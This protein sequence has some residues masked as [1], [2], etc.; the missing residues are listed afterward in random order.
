MRQ[1]ACRATKLKAVT[2][3]VEASPG[4][5][6]PGM[7]LLFVSTPYGGLCKTKSP[8]APPMRPLEQKRIM[9]SNWWEGSGVSDGR[10]TGIVWRYLRWTRWA[11]LALCPA[12]VVY[13][14]TLLGRKSLALQIGLQARLLP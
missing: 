8:T 12:G 9:V 14:K 5:G 2:I 10:Q 3:D 13:S 7:E 4:L 11:C 6:L 1:K